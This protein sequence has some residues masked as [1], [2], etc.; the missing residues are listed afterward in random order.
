MQSLLPPDKDY[1]HIDINQGNFDKVGEII[2][3]VVNGNLYIV[4]DCAM[5]GYRSIVEKVYSIIT[6]YNIPEEKVFLVSGATDIKDIVLNY[7][8][9]ISKKPINSMWM[10]EFEHYVSVQIKDK[11]LNTSPKNY[12]KSF[13]CLNRRWRLQR[14]AFVAKLIQNE[15]LPYGYVSLDLCDLPNFGWDDI[16]DS[17][18][19]THSDDTDFVNYINNNIEHLKRM[20]PLR[21]DVE[22]RKLTKPFELQP[23]LDYFYETSFF[24]VVTETNYYT[25]SDTYVSN[26]GTICEATRFLTEKTFKP[27]AYFHPFVLV[28]TPNMLSLLRELGYKTFSPFINES[29]DTE[30]NDCRRMNLIIEEVKRLS[31]MNDA[32]RDTFLKNVE[33]ICQHNYQLLKSRYQELFDMRLTT[34]FRS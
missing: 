14:P 15:L 11:V 18:I 32:Q 33:P 23:E 6:K 19:E 24:S 26:Y 27:M 7:S 34:D 2:D 25:N 22:S 8:K 5:E 9:T 29:Y 30:P 28:S 20:T 21:L 13:L 12:K 3:K 1:Y 16:L 10:K 31:S 17:I 4:F